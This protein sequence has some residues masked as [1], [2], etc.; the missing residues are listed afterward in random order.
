MTFCFSYGHGVLRAPDPRYIALQEFVETEPELLNSPIIQLVRKVCDLEMI[1]RC[2]IS[3]E[4]FKT[5]E[6]APGVLKEHGKVRA[7]FLQI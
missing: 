1:S 7:H 6:V 3:N 4:I 5:F 2:M